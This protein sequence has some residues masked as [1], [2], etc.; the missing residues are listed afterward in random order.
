MKTNFDRKDPNGADEY[1]LNCVRKGDVKNALDCFD[2]EAIYIDKDGNAISGLSNIEK[3]V[4]NLC[5]MKPD[6]TV[7][8][9]KIAPIGDNMMYW[10]D[11]WKMTTTDPS[12]NVIEMKGASANVMRK[13]ADGFWLWLV[14][15]P[16]A[17]PF[18]AND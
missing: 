2:L 17:A 6:I 11:K 18:F 10:L 14:D 5:K 3:V 15:N 12:G 7:Y 1:F 9:H 16:F 8:E 13:S 4:I